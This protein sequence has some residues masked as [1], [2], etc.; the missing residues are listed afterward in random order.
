MVSACLAAMPPTYKS[1]DK[2]FAKMRGYP[3]WPA[4]VSSCVIVTLN[5]IYFLL[6]EIFP[7][8]NSEYKNLEDLL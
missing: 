8:A 2:I 3:H 7:N 4:R 5:Q 1:G 6:F